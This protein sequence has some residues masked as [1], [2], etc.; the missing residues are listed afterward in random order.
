MKKIIFILIA[1]V[2]AVSCTCAQDT[3]QVAVTVTGTV[4]NEQKEPLMGVTVTVKDQP[5]LGFLPTTRENT[6][7]KPINTSG[8]FFP[9]LATNKWK[10]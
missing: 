5:G 3:A 1:I 4:V 7:S 10:C 2:G 9:L 8:W 6:P